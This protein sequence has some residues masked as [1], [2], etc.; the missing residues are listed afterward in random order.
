MWVQKKEQKRKKRRYNAVHSHRTRKE[1]K[2][3]K[4]NTFRTNEKKKYNMCIINEKEKKNQLSNHWSVCPPLLPI[5]SSIIND[6]L[7]E[8]LCESFDDESKFDLSLL[9]NA[10][11]GNE[12][13]E[14]SPDGGAEN[15]L[16][17]E[18]YL[19]ELWSCRYDEDE[20]RSGLRDDRCDDECSWLLPRWLPREK[21]RDCPPSPRPIKQ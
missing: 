18:V 7:F 17:D 5:V 6:D 2:K 11:L 10:S 12:R 16:V 13:C 9:R 21:N 4:S 8:L 14:N 15:P 3:K 1:K 20:R 19:S